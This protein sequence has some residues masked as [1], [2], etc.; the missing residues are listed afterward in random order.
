VAKNGGG[1]G[2]IK[3]L[4]LKSRKKS[5]YKLKLIGLELAPMVAFYGNNVFSHLLFGLSVA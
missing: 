2:G 3:M 1:G 4:E 5:Y